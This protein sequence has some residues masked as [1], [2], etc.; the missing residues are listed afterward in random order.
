MIA[1]NQD[2]FGRSFML[3]RTCQ[4]T[5]PSDTEMATKLP[6]QFHAIL[7]AKLDEVLRQQQMVKLRI[8]KFNFLNITF[9][10]SL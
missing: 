1:N 6:K 4:V 10:L 8:S 2:N 5:D 3:D 7:C 9:S